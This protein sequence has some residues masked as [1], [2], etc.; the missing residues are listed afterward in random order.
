[1]TKK[2]QQWTNSLPILIYNKKDVYMENQKHLKQVHSA[3]WEKWNI[4]IKEINNTGRGGAQ[5]QEGFLCNRRRVLLCRSVLPHFWTMVFWSG[6]SSQAR[7]KEC[8]TWKTLCSGFKRAPTS[9]QWD[10]LPKI[11]RV[12]R[13]LTR[14]SDYKKE[15]K[16]KHFTNPERMKRRSFIISSSSCTAQQAPRLHWIVFLTHSYSVTWRRT[17]FPERNGGARI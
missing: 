11:S 17:S 13:K 1:M 10:W 9:G 4:V 2:R 7:N 16:K 12:T 8:V 3:P 6:L 14:I 5:Q 15:K